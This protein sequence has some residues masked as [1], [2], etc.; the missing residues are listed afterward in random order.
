MKF[1]SLFLS[2]TLTKGIKK[3]CLIDLE[4]ATYCSISN[5]LYNV[6]KKKKNININVL[7]KEYSENDFKAATKFLNSTFENPIFDSINS[8][9]RTSILIE[10][11]M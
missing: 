4:R 9:G 5:E 2:C 1:F 10:N 7:R 3:S 11:F 6:L 8:S